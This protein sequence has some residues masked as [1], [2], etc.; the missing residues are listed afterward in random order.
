MPNFTLQT[1]SAFSV[2]V[3]LSAALKAIEAR[4]DPLMSCGFYNPL[5]SLQGCQGSSKIAIAYYLYSPIV[6]LIG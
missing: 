4:L 6:F 1:Y 3:P 2:E 5:L